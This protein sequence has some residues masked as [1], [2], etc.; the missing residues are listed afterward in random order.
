M[1]WIWTVLCIWSPLLQKDW[2]IIVRDQIYRVASLLSLDRVKAVLD[3]KAAKREFGGRLACDSRNEKNSMA[4]ALATCVSEHWLARSGPARI[5]VNS[6]TWRDC[7]LV[8]ISVTDIPKQTFCQHRSRPSHWGTGPQYIVQVIY[9]FGESLQKL[10]FPH[11]KL[12]RIFFKYHY[13]TSFYD[14]L[15]SPLCHCYIS[16]CIE[17][18]PHLNKQ[19]RGQ[20]VPTYSGK[21]SRNWIIDR[22]KVNVWMCSSWFVDSVL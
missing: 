8:L 18:V 15:I 1:D 13:I 12:W 3:V 7:C 19:A 5:P 16:K 20:S 6:V 14:W 10:F 22:P 2:Q 11:S 4:P 9:I 17:D 21:Q